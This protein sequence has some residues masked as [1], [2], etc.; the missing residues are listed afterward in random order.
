MK[1]TLDI[2]SLIIRY[3]QNVIL[4]NVYLRLEQG[5]IT[6]LFGRNGT[7][8]SSL[9]QFIIGNIKPVQGQL[10]FNGQFLPSSKITNI[11][12]FL[13]QYTF[14]PPYLTV[15]QVLSDYNLKPEILVSYFPLFQNRLKQKIK[16]FSGGEKRL[17]EFFIIITYDSK[18][19]ILDEPFASIMPKHTETMIKL[20]QSQKIKKGILI[21]DHQN[22]LVK[23]CMD[24]SYRIENHQIISNNL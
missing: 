4:N 19:C 15:L 11:I 17:L 13:P 6:G 20:I 23:T 5:Q 7:G 8:K 3:S 22:D 21:C 9:M 16:T 10:R 2:D 1:N 12:S 24:Q 14:I 18:F